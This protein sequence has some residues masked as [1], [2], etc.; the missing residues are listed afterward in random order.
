M[1]K[2]NATLIMNDTTFSVHTSQHVEVYDLSLKL[3]MGCMAY[4]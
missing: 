3:K 1:Q 2:K 4:E